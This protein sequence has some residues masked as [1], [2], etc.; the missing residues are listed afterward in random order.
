M[1]IKKLVFSALM[2][3]IFCS[4]SFAL[5][6]IEALSLAEKNN[7]EL[8]SSKKQFESYEWSYKKSFSAFLP[9]L[10][11]NTS[12]RENL[13][14]TGKTYSYGLSVTQSLFDGGDNI[15]S[16]QKSYADLEYYKA[17][18]ILT[19]ARVLYDIRSAFVEVSNL[20]EKIDILKKILEMRRENTR[21]MA[22]RYKSGRE[23]KGNLM[24]TKSDQVQAEY[25]MSSTKRDLKL[26]KLKL[27]Q[28]LC[29]D[30][31]D[32]KDELSLVKTEARFDKL[33]APSSV[34]VQ[35]F[36][37]LA[38]AVP[39][40]IMEKYQLEKAELNYKATLSGFLPSVSVSG[41]YGKSG[42]DWPPDTA[43]KS[44]SLNLSYSFF[45]GGANIADRAIYSA[46]LDQAKEDYK[47]SV[48]DIR[49]DLE[50]AYEDFNDSIEAYKAAQ[51]SQAAAKERAMISKAKYLNGL[52]NYDDWDRIENSYVSSQK[53]LLNYK[54][55]ALL[56][57]AAWHKSYGGYVK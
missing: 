53:N 7:N 4:S 51:I 13:Y 52:T 19:R 21:L 5:T 55:S 27:N 28:L 35:N 44:W 10:S 36:E 41:S 39:S 48:K 8:I 1:V 49:Y 32:P 3:G 29:E 42:S 54:K 14:T 25:D 6:W 9:Q 33:T 45:N 20:Q 56:A 12:A 57:E 2:I 11:A 16:L 34:E 22:L 46:K 18:L 30:V 37:R 15:I 50:K 31:S 43:S 40:Y 24:Q 26:A 47:N 38:E 23:D 17:N